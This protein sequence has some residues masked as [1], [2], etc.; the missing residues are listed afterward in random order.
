MKGYFCSRERWRQG[1]SRKQRSC[2][3]SE[4]TTNTE[5]FRCPRNRLINFDCLRSRRFIRSN[6]RQVEKRLRLF[7]SLRDFAKEDDKLY[8]LSIPRRATRP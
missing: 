5:S 6:I 1:R 7:D 8:A 3:N 4:E 2:S